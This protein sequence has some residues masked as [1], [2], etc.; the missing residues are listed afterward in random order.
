VRKRELE[1]ENAQL[2]ESLGTLDVRLSLAESYR[3]DHYADLSKGG[4]S[5]LDKHGTKRNRSW[6]DVKANLE[7]AFGAWCVNSFA[8]SYVDYIKFF[9]IGRGTTVS[10]EDTDVEG[11]K[12][13]DLFIKANDWTLMEKDIT[14]ESARDGEIFVRFHATNKFRIESAVSLISLIDPLEVID[15][16]V[17]DKGEPEFYLRR[18]NVPGSSI[19]KE[20]EIPA[21][22]IHH[23]KLNSSH[24][25][26]RGRSDLLPALPWLKMHKAWLTDMA[27]RNYYS[28]AVNWDVK[29]GAGIKPT[30]VS[31]K[32]PTG[33]MPGTVIVH[34]ENEEWTVNSP[35]MKYADSTS[36]ARAIKLMIC[37][38]FKMPESWF[39]DTGESN[40]A[41][42]AAL[43]MPT[44]KAFIDRQDTLQIHFEAII[45]RGA[46]VENVKVE[47]PELVMEEA[48][49]KAQALFQL[50]Q[51]FT[52]LIANNMISSETAYGLLKSFADELPE[53]E[54]EKAR[55]EGED[56]ESVA[57]VAAGQSTSR[58]PRPRLEEEGALSVGG[59]PPAGAQVT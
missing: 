43:A 46:G 15:I 34:G 49:V 13:I 9:V 11:Q 23:I 12:R 36:G 10:A 22:E 55:I 24:N 1:A 18:W 44:L 29:V 5:A 33:P 59:V 51:A 32:Y 38:L 35:D 57:K 31:A 45:S 40:L 58:P 48:N 54:D 28:G 26:Q 20:E 4:W 52:N 56:A 42:T 53:W 17:D 6:S 7:D 3:S 14:G 50:S 19:P 16:L 2:K 21:S 25:E 41:T 37:A 8:R 39:G 30:D 47:F 27:R